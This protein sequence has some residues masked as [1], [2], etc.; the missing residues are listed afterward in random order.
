MISGQVTGAGGEKKKG[1]KKNAIRFSQKNGT[2]SAFSHLV[3]RRPRRRSAAS[4][5][6]SGPPLL[7]RNKVSSQK[8]KSPPAAPLSSPPLREFPAS[9]GAQP[10]IPSP[11]SSLRHPSLRFHRPSPQIC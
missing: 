9:A 2:V 6:P 4:S 3:R 5:S 8:K 1:K 7:M 10:P 11:Q